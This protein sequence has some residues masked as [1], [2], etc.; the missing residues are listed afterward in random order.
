MSWSS[1]T[2]QKNL[3]SIRYRLVQQW[4]VDHFQGRKQIENMVV[5]AWKWVTVSWCLDISWAKRFWVRNLCDVMGETPWTIKSPLCQHNLKYH[6]IDKSTIFYMNI[7]IMNVKNF[8]WKPSLILDDICRSLAA[9]VI[10]SQ[11][12]ELIPNPQSGGAYY[13]YHFPAWFGSVIYKIGMPWK[14]KIGFRCTL[15]HMIESGDWGTR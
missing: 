14:T 6:T 10:F 2:L 8:L 5:K 12:S 1:L 3:S 11:K 7:R 13:I 9:P 15:L 4:A